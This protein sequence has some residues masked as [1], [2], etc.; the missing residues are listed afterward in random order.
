MILGILRA[1]GIC[2]AWLVLAG[3]TAWAAAALY[4]DLP[5]ADAGL[6]AAIVY[7]ATI[8]AALILV[9]GHRG[10]AMARARGSSPAWTSR[11]SR[12]R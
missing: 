3:L 12:S 11:S 4:I 8:A 2:L 7:L 10:K 1:A 6:P 9:P 5:I